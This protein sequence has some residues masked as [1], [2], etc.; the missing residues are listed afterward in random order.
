[1]IERE[2]LFQSHVAVG[3][4]YQIY[5]YNCILFNFIYAITCNDLLQIIRQFFYTFLTK[6]RKLLSLILIRES[7]P[8]SKRFAAIENGNSRQV[9]G[10]IITVIF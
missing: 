6:F 4:P 7:F 5:K 8:Q 10:Q 1:M 9:Q 3:N 2:P